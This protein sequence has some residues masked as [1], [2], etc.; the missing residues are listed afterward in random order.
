MD[1]KQWQAWRA[2]I[3]LSDLAGLNYIIEKLDPTKIEDAAIL[4]HAE[5][6]IH[7]L[8]NSHISEAERMGKLMA[9]AYKEEIAAINKNIQIGK[10]L[11][12]KGKGKF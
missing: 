12:T 9:H 6:K 5:K 7:A 8:V 2:Q 3:D 4:Y 11:V 1:D 10:S